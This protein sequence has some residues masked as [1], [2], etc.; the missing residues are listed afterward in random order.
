M[1]SGD[2]V[3]RLPFRHAR[4]FGHRTNFKSEFG[5]CRHL[6]W[7]IICRLTNQCDDRKLATV[8]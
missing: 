3:Y 1:F 7:F 2:N 4:C 8:I 5:F 6:D